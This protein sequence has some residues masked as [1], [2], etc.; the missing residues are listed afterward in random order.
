MINSNFI[1]VASSQ[2]QHH[3]QHMLN[4]HF[5][6]GNTFISHFCNNKNPSKVCLSDRPTL[7]HFILEDAISSLSV[8]LR[9]SNGLTHA[10]K[11]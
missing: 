9:L 11:Q 1:K 4:A 5:N 7:D 3:K 10:L 6:F 8:Y 2:T